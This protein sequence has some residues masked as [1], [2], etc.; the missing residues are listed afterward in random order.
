[1]NVLIEYGASLTE[2]DKNDHSILH[3]LCDVG[4]SEILKVQL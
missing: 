4:N 1:M 2:V 3:L